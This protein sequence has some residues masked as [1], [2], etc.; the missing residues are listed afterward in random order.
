[1]WGKHTPR[2]L[3]C[4]DICAERLSTKTEQNPLVAVQAKG[5]RPHGYDDGVG[6]GD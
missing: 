1:M 4:Q 3:S 5:L 2:E 6:V